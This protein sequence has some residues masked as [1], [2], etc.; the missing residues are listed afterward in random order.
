MRKV[1][2]RRAYRCGCE[3]LEPRVVLSHLARFGAVGDSLTDEYRF[4][5][6][7]RSRARNWVETLAG[8]RKA[9]FGTYSTRDR[10]LPRSQGYANNWAKENSRTGDVVASQLAGLASQV[11]AGKVDYAAVGMGT[12]DFLFFLED[13]AT[14][15]SDGNPPADFAPRLAAVAQNAAANLDATVS[16]L[17]AASPTVK[18]IVETT[19]DIRQ[20]PIV[21]QYLTIP[22]AKQAA[23]A[24]AAVQATYNAHIRQVAATTPRVAVADIAAQALAN[25]AGAT[26][27]PFGGTTL[28]LTVTGDDYR[29]AILAD[30]IHPG[31][32]AQGIIAD[33]II[34]AADSLGATITPLSPAQIVARARYVAGHFRTAR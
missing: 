10:G 7:D 6:P 17:L 20:V 14:R 9:D 2:D 29:D 16:T 31:T 19:P 30:K 8:A 34:Q 3:A 28:R 27:L 4:Y 12:N 13:V 26:K 32:I 15:T 5:A 23:D 33:T 1:S 18:V 25:P 21:A 24:V 22:A 11:A